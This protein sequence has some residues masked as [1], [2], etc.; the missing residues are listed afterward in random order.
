MKQLLITTVFFLFSLNLV[1]QSTS[2]PK[3]DNQI[4]EETGIYYYAQ[5]MPE[6][7]NGINALRK[8]I[9]MNYNIPSDYDGTGGHVVLRFVVN[10]DGDI[11]D[12]KVL[13]GI[14]DCEQCNLEG[15][16]AVNSLSQKFTP[17]LQ[18]GEP[19]KIYFTLPIV[20]KMK[21]KKKKK[22]EKKDE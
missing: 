5:V 10:E 22:R 8:E 16:R 4:D 2:K 7:P 19:V 9:S 17:A 18:D 15:I 14:K 3:Q 11:S 6:Y 21:G 20:V 13:K 1:A 12:T